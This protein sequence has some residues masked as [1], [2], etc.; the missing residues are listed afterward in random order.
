MHYLDSLL[1]AAEEVCKEQEHEGAH[2][3]DESTPLKDELVSLDRTVPKRRT[4]EDTLGIV[5]G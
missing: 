5:T 3:A 4:R 2:T 1:A